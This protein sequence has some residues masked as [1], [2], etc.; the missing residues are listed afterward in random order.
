MN[1]PITRRTRFLLEDTHLVAFLILVFI[2]TLRKFKFSYLFRQGAP[3]WIAVCENPRR[4]A[5]S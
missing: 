1:R 5:E 2:K 4:I 3:V